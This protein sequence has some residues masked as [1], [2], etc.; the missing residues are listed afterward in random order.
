MQPETQQFFDRLIAVTKPDFRP[1]RKSIAEQYVT[2]ERLSEKQLATVTRTASFNRMILPPE[3][4]TAI[5]DDPNHRR[6]TRD[7][8]YLDL[9]RSDR[10]LRRDCSGRSARRYRQSI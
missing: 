4:D 10:A 8:R 7:D 3:L 9:E 2:R 1:M 6:D 5:P